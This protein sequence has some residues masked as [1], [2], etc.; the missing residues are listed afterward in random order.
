MNPKDLVTPELVNRCS[1]LGAIIVLGY[2]KTG[3]LPIAKKLSQE[4]NYPLIISDDY[5]QYEDPLGT[6]TNI[7]YNNGREVIVEG[8]LCYRL[9]RKEFTN[10]FIPGVIIKTACNDETIKHFYRQDREEH[11]I[12]RALSFN[13]GLGK[14]WDE[15]KDMLRNNIHN[16]SPPRYIELNTTLPEFSY[17]S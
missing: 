10:N 12:K 9:L 3:K 4:L 14:I 2:T 17:F 5:L 6:L 13:K 1:N 11:K 16:I 8:T 15:Y 7:M